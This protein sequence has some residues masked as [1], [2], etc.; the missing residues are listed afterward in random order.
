MWTLLCT[1]VSAAGLAVKSMQA[2]SSFHK[3]RK[4]SCADFHVRTE[5]LGGLRP[6]LAKH[7]P[8]L[9]KQTYPINR[10]MFRCVAIHFLTEG[11]GGLR[12]SLT[13]HPPWLAT[14]TYPINGKMSRCAPIHSRME[15]LGGLRPSL[16]KPALQQFSTKTWPIFTDAGA[17]RNSAADS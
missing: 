12:P 13:K 6:S 2:Y 10:K 8:R 11:L 7:P 5:G 17:T 1:V 14:Q 15:G 16:A 4:A 3:T 9:A